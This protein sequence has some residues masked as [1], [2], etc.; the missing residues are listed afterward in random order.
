MATLGFMSDNK[1]SYSEKLQDPR[2]KLKRQE[3]VDRDNGKCAL[4]GSSV[5]IEVHHCYYVATRQPWEYP[6]DSLVCVCRDCHQG[7]TDGNRANFSNWESAA[8]AVIRGVIATHKQYQG[9]K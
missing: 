6:N 3:I 7:I 9:T 5:R 1:M 4:C 8:C 2:W